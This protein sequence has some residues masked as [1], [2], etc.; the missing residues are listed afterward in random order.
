MAS[1]QTPEVPDLAQA[2]SLSGR[3]LIEFVLVLAAVLV[4]VIHGHY[5]A[6]FLVVL[7]IVAMVVLHEFGHYLVARW[8]GMKVREFFIGF[9]PKIWSFRAGGIEYGLKAF[10]VGGYVKI[11]GMTGIDE[12]PEEEEAQSYRAATF[13]R[14]V[15]VSAAGSV[16]HFLVAFLLLWYLFSGIGVA[17]GKTTTITSVISSSKIS[18]PAARAHIPAGSVVAAAGGIGYPTVNQFAQLISRSTGRRVQLT[19]KTGSGYLHTSVVPI[20]SAVLAKS[21]PAYATSHPYGVIGVSISPGV[22]RKPLLSG[23]GAA[24]TGLGDYG[25]LSLSALLSHFSPQGIATYVSEVTHPSASSTSAKAQSRFASPVGIV[26]LANDAAH[27]GLSAVIELLVMINIFVGV[28]NL[29][30]LLPL[31]GGHV[32]IAIYERLRSRRGRRYHADVMK[33]MPLTYAVI[34]V[35]L[36]LGVTALYLDISHPITNP[37]G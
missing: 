26:T 9:G 5:V 29:M 17:T 33:L 10:L 11:V 14:R 21:D 12:V 37:F 2:R 6:T 30:P 24:A 19:L 31:D 18:T 35:I 16:V 20:S 25:V 22:V 23:V 36:L 8:S 13:P 27:A 28:F 7:G 3:R 34:A 1:G 32:V 15:A 4:Y